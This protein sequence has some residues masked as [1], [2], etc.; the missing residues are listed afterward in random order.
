MNR[1]RIIGKALIKHVL[2]SLSDA[3]L[4]AGEQAARK[5]YAEP[6]IFQ[7]E[8][9]QQAVM[10]ALADLLL[11]TSNDHSEDH[12]YPCL[13]PHQMSAKH[14]GVFFDLKR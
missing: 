6:D 5:L 13:K 4:L 3:I 8:E 10:Y 11:L 2:P 14:V 9:T 7:I 12:I 1:K